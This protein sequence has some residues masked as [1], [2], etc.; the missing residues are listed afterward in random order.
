MDVGVALLKLDVSK[1]GDLNNCGKWNLQ[2]RTNQVWGPPSPQFKENL[3][4]LVVLTR[5]ECAVD[6]SPPSRTDV[7]NEW[8]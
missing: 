8:S 5:P 6:R 3:G 1:S 2:T 4:S 7:Q